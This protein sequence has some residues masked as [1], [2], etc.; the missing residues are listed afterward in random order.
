MPSTLPRA[1]VRLARSII[2]ASVG[3]LLLTLWWGCSRSL[4]GD[5]KTTPIEESDDQTATLRSD[6]EASPPALV[7]PPGQAPRNIAPSARPI[8]LSELLRLRRAAFESVLAS[9]DRVADGALMYDERSSTPSYVMGSRPSDSSASDGTAPN[10]APTAQEA[11][12][13]LPLPALAHFVGIENESSLDHFHEA[14]TRL[15]AGQDEDGRVRLLAYGA[16]HTQADVYPGYLRAYLQSRFGN[17]GQGFVLLGRVNH[18][19]RTLDT[20]VRHRHMTVHHSRYRVDVENEPLGL[21]G[22]AFVANSGDAF[23]EITTSKHSPNTRFEVQYYAQPEGGRIGIQVDSRLLAR[24]STQSDTAKLAYYT[25]EATPGRHSI[26]VKRAGRGEVRLFG[27]VA[28]TAQPGVVVDTLGISGAQMTSQLRWDEH[29]W[30]EA[31]RHRN[32]DL[33]TFAY[34]TNELADPGFSL[35]EYGRQLRIVL[36]RLR[37][38]MPQVSCLLISPFDLPTRHAGR[39]VTKPRLLELIQLQRQV[40]KEFNCGFWNGL[41]FTGGDGSLHRWVKANP[42]LATPDYIHLTRLGYAYAGVAL[43]DAIMRKFDLMHAQK[44]SRI[45]DNQVAHP[46]GQ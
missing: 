19:Y 7:S 31:I 29:V 18:W 3:A 10:A 28:E 32:P 25:F 13:P 36:G 11:S 37:Q 2:G 34:G 4:I 35:P 45:G 17:G 26:L 9:S 43:G 46:D 8:L 6:G 30:T 15:E 22:A 42:P 5:S 14:L 40:S 33:V 16:S 41:A 21:F 39:W 1:N 44:L 12:E 27:I 20:N 23:G 38:A 24:I